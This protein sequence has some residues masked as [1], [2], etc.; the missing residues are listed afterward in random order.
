[1]TALIELYLV[2]SLHHMYSKVSISCFK[3]RYYFSLHGLL[4][5]PG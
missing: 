1:M 5:V 4:S 3:L 2:T